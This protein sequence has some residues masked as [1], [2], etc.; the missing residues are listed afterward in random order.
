MIKNTGLITVL[1]TA[2]FYLLPTSVMA[3]DG[4][5][6][7]QIKYRGSFTTLT[8]ETDIARRLHCTAYDANNYPLHASTMDVTP[9][10]SKIVL[11]TGT[12]T[13]NVVSAKCQNTQA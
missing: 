9:V 8:I 6:V 12:Q 5:Q 11:Y 13:K 1:L 2:S 3:E 7:K 4:F 10:S